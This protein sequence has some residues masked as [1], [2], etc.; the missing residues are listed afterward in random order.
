MDSVTDYVKGWAWRSDIP[1][2]PLDIHIYVY[3]NS[4]RE[5]VT[6]YVTNANLYRSDLVSA[7]IGN[8]Y[9]GFSHYIDWSTFVPDTYLVQVFAIGHN[10]D[11]PALTYSPMAYTVTSTLGYKGY[12]VYRDLGN[13]AGGIAGALGSPNDWHAGLM[14]EKYA[15]INLSVIEMPG[16]GHDIQWSNWS[17]FVDGLTYRGTYKPKQAISDNSRNL[18]ICLARELKTKDIGY[19]ALYQ[20]R[21]TVRPEATKIEP[22]D[23]VD[24]RCDGLVEYCYEYFGFRVFGNDTYWDISKA[25][26]GNIAH[27]NENNIMPKAQAQQY[28]NLVTTSIPNQ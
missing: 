10:G 3:R 16:I 22:D 28:L 7:G 4:P 18:I 19:I 24:I 12:A 14:D 1:N 27:H 17:D 26:A 2:T 6:T 13:F 23:V 21:A 15:N 11:N 25:S 20:I 9:H 8:G 5:L